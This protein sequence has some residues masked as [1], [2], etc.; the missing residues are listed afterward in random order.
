MMFS[1]S[2]CSGFVLPTLLLLP[3][4][5][6]RKLQQ[7][8][9]WRTHVKQKMAQLPEIAKINKSGQEARGL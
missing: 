4:Q 7:S 2:L 9:S 6:V 3:L 1:E 8:K 5:P